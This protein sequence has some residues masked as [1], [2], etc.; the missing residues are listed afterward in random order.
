[1]LETLDIPPEDPAEL[2]AANRLLADEVKALT[3]KVEHLQNQLAGHNRHRFVSRSEGLDQLAMIFAEDEQIVRLAEEQA[4]PSP[5]PERDQP[6]KRH[7]RNPLPAHLK[8]KDQLLSPSD[9][10]SRCG[11]TLKTLGEDVTEELEYVPGRFVVNRIIR[12]RMA[13]ACCETIVQAPMPSRPIKRGRPGPGLLAHVLVTK[14]A[15]YLPLYR[16]SQIYAREG[17]ELDRSAMADWGGRSTALPEPLADAIGRMVRQGVALS[18]TGRAG[19]P[20][21]LE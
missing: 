10:C 12:P 2:R 3:L 5:A 21:G 15:D 18:L 17:V 1:M 20:D 11:G 8:R 14:Y 9:T 13:R 7:G 4:N 19:S 6:R 16:Q